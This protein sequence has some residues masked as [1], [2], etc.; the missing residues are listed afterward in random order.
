[1]PL[2]LTVSGQTE[3][4]INYQDR[5]G[6]DYYFPPLYKRL[7]QPGESIVY[8]TGKYPYLG[9]PKNCYVG[10]GFVGEVKQMETEEGKAMFHS[11]I[12]GYSE[13]FHPVPFK[14]LTTYL[15]P[16]A[17]SYPQKSVGLHFRQG[18]RKIERQ[19]FAQIMNYGFSVCPH[20]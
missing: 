11:S 20:T 10:V 19:S 7:I 18:V 12:L 4:G 15:E 16:K 1:M 2:V 3:S 9:F 5:L 14:T 17:N 8:Y 6:S 13:F